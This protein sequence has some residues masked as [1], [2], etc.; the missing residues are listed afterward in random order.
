[1][2]NCGQSTLDV[3]NTG[4]PLEAKKI[5]DLADTFNM[6][7]EDYFTLPDKPGLSVELNR[8]VVEAHLA[9]GEKWWGS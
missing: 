9:A 2:N 4:D 8:E 6:P 7:K 3:R 1:M 5:T